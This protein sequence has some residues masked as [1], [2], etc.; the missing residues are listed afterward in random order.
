MIVDLFLVYSLIKRLATPFEK[1]DAFK[2]GIIDKDG[3]ILKKRKDLT[4]TAEYKAFGIFDLMIL[5]L[6]ALLGKLPGGQTKLASYAAA[7]WL[8]KEQKEILDHGEN[9]S[10]AHIISKFNTYLDYVNES[11]DINHQFEMMLED[12]EGLSGVAVN[13]V[14]SGN[15]AGVGVGLQGEPGFYHKRKTKRV[16]DEFDFRTN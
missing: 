2:L 11:I 7:L 15:I 8:I 14:G 1:W 9:L 6:K 12:G 5:K 16:K 13:N 10:E 3:N 4:T